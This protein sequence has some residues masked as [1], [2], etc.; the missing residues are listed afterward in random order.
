MPSQDGRALLVRPLELTGRGDHGAGRRLKS[1]GAQAVDEPT[2]WC[3]EVEEA[4]RLRP[5]V[6]EAVHS[7]GGCGDERSGAGDV[8]LVPDAELDLTVEHVERVGV[9][10]VG[11]RVDALESRLEAMRIAV[12]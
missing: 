5:C 12:N 6:A 1:V 8:R 9:V 11:V 7:P 2:G 10:G 4:D 3:V